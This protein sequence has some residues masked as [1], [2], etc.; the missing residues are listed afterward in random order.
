MLSSPLTPSAEG[1]VSREYQ[2]KAVFLYNFAQFV[3]WPPTAF[4]SPSAPL[5]IGVL[6]AD[7]FGA[8]LDETVKG[9]AIGNH[10][11]VIAR[12]NNVQD[13]KGCQLI[14]VSD[15][16]RDHVSDILAALDPEAVLTV[17]DIESFARRGGVINFFLQGNK[18]RFEINPTSARHE[19]IRI[20]SQLLSLGRIIDPAAA[21]AH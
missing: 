21:E 7:P 20:S 16:E 9:E 10:K 8:A 12:S 1:V 2:I 3:E 14:F 18:V 6:G 5:C 4:A 15:S 17:S 13:L 11:L 19:G